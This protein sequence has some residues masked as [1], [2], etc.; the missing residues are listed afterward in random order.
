LFCLRV[1]ESFTFL[2]ECWSLRPDPIPAGPAVTTWLSGAGIRG[3]GIS[4]RVLGVFPHGIEG[5]GPVRVQSIAQRLAVDEVTRQSGQVGGD[6][7]AEVL[8]PLAFVQSVTL[9][10]NRGDQRLVLGE[11]F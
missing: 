7:S 11:S 9:Q 3:V 4:A 6:Q 8:G 2:A 10:S 1:P 5:K